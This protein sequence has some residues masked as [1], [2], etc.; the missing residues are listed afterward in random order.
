MAEPYFSSNPIDWRAVDGIYIDEQEPPRPVTVGGAG[1]VGF[2]DEFPWGEPDT[3]TLITSAKQLVE[4]FF[5]YDNVERQ[6]YGDPDD[7]SNYPGYGGPRALFGLSWPLLY[8]VRVGHSAQAKATGAPVDNT[9]KKSLNLHALYVGTA[10]NSIQY[11]VVNNT[12]T[13]D[14]YVKWGNRV[15]VFA[16][17][18]LLT[19]KA[20]V[21]GTS[22][23]V[24]VADGD[25]GAVLP[26][27]PTAY[28]AMTG[29]S[30]GTPA[31]ADYS[32]SD[33]NKVGFRCFS[34]LP[35]VELFTAGSFADATLDGSMK[36]WLAERGYGVFFAN[37]EADETL[38]TATAAARTLASER[39]MRLFCHVQVA[40]PG[41]GGL[42]DV[43]PSSRAA[44]AASRISPHVDI[45]AARTKTSWASVSAL[46]SGRQL[47]RGDYVEA[48]SGNLAAVERLAGGGFKIRSG[49]LSDGTLL[50]ER[51]MA[52]LINRTVGARMEDF[53]N[54]PLDDDLK[55]GMKSTISD[56]LRYLQ[57]APRKMV[58]DYEVDDESL[59]TQESEDAGEWHL[60]SKAKLYASARFIVVHSQVGATVNITN[61]TIE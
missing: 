6:V 55:A 49:V 15:E 21:N 58:K 31:A 37:G 13:F 53:Q 38:A 47:A 16:G 18:T 39:V 20:A 35:D 61:T 2:V 22:K 60:L 36:T 30:N 14:L 46:E 25:S 59:N 40:M 19:M 8:V 28:K 42:F 50:F 43:P 45:A 10:G 57:A 4:T 41:T 33:V 27:E 26:V 11:K 12:T 24:T 54:E 48:L 3:P 29:G 9:S 23:L 7:L 56:Y 1:K 17:L 32:G 34:D 51:R 44:N 5:G 52:D